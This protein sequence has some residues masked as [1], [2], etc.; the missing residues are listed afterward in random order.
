MSNDEEH[1]DHGQFEQDGVAR[2]ADADR[3]TDTRTERRAFRGRWQGRDMN[4]MRRG[5][6]GRGRGP[7]G[8]GGGRRMRRG[9]I[10]SAVLQVLTEQDGHGYELI[11]ALEA[12]TDGAWRPS[13]GSVYP[14][15]QLLE[16]TGMV[17]S[18]E[19]DGKR[20]YSITDEGRAEA[21]RLLDD[22]GAPPWA[23]V[24]RGGGIRGAMMQ[25]AAAARQVGTA[26][27]ADQVERAV[28]VI[29]TARK[30]LYKILAED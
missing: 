10:R 3:R 9:E 8:P 2:D 6:H 30:E 25:L 1:H 19:R 27:S 14:T 24:A 16:D 22:A 18:S 23:D 17:R 5:P 4:D 21:Q 11:Q 20:V 26:G 15:L 7:F 13:P 12:K 29:T 28:L